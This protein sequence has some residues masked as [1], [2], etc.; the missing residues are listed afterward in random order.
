MLPR[1]AIE[2]YKQLYK[3]RFYIELSDEEASFRTNNLVNLY[4]AVYGDSPKQST[5]TLRL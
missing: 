4:K 3:N 1:E 5:D 2:E